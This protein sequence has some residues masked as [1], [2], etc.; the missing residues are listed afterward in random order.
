MEITA[1]SVSEF[2]GSLSVPEGFATIEPL[3]I[4]VIGLVIYSLFV[5]KFYKFIAKKDIFK[6]SQERGTL[7]KI[8]YALKYIFLFPIVSFFWFFVIAV[9]VSMLS[10]VLD[11]GNVFM[12]SMAIITTVRISAYYDEELSRE[13]AKLIPLA[14][15]GVL[16]LDISKISYNVPL[17]VINQISAVASVLAYYFIFLIILEFIL[18]AVNYAIKRN[19]TTK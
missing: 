7:G 19:K 1:A 13:V 2:I 5:F 11:I 16:L 12:V 6:L 9:L 3:I 15:L 8:I 14:M 18:R 17:Q 4:F 10:G